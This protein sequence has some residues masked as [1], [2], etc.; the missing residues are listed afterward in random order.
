MTNVEM[1]K[2][3]FEDLGFE[4]PIFAEKDS[5]NF[6]ALGLCRL[7]CEMGHNKLQQFLTE[8]TGKDWSYEQELVKLY[9]TTRDLIFRDLKITETKRGYHVKDKKLIKE[10]ASKC[11]KNIPQNLYGELLSNEKKE[12]ITMNKKSTIKKAVTKKA[13]SKKKA[14]AKKAAPK[15]TAP[16]KKATTK[17]DAPKETAP[18]KK[19]AT[20]SKGRKSAISRTAKIKILVKGNPKRE[21]TISH[22]MF[23]LYRKNKTV[24]SFLENGGQWLYIHYDLKKKFI[25]VS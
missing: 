20:S 9:S 3:Y 16:T 7:I 6:Y 11:V 25:S 5:G 18:A 2:T 1:I 24:G 12:Y 8:V 13:T 4:L 17:K 21:G 22:R 10:Y 15:K 19:A 23:E 14:P